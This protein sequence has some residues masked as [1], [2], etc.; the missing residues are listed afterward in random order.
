MRIFKFLMFLGLFYT[1]FGDLGQYGLFDQ[2]QAMVLVKKAT[3]KIYAVEV[4]SANYYIWKLEEILP[5]HPI[6]PIMQAFLIQWQNMPI[7]EGATFARLEAKLLAT[8]EATSKLNAFD[9]YDIEAVYF[10]LI[11]RGLLAEY[12]AEDRRYLDAFTEGNKMYGLIKKG[13][14]LVDKQPEFLFTAGLYNYFRVAYPEKHPVVLPFALFFK[15]GD[16]VL[17]LEQIKKATEVGVL[18][19]IEAK[20]Y[21]AYVYLRYEQ[22][23][24]EAYVILEGLVHKY[25]SNRYFVAKFL[26]AS[27]ATKQ[28]QNIAPWMLDFLIA[29]PREYDKMVGN[30]FMAIHL[31][32]IDKNIE[33]AYDYYGIGIEFGKQLSNHGEYFKSIGYLGLARLSAQFGNVNTSRSY[34]NLC[35]EFAETADVTTAAALGLTK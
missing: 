2:P 15:K 24:M 22:T 28:Y 21:L 13:F 20:M 31:E 8:I 27:Y 34:Y 19:K 10:E 18:S 25:P 35:L 17:G 11:A 16:K 9:S 6:V 23:P 3:D 7:F 32:F 26:E 14:D 30:I 33:Q 4:D 12:Y 1:N 29:S 5:N